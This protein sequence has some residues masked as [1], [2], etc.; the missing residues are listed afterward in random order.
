MEEHD[1]IGHGWAE[2]H[3]E[4]ITIAVHV[5]GV[6]GMLEPK[7]KRTYPLANVTSWHT[8]GESIGFGVGNLGLLRN[9]R[10]R[11]PEPHL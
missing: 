3:D 5:K 1:I 6:V 4:A 11:G 2:I 8:S 10:C 9:Q 7:E